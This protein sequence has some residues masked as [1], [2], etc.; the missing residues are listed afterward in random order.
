MSNASSRTTALAADRR[1]FSQRRLT[2]LLIA[3]AVV[4]GPSRGQVAPEPPVAQPA[5]PSAA[6]KSL[7][8]DAFG[9]APAAQVV[10]PAPLAL[11]AAP[12]APPDIA[13]AADTTAAT[14][15]TAATEPSG[16]P[17]GSVGPLTPADGGYGP[18]VFAGSDGRF[19]A[20]LLRRL[21]TPVASRWAH[22]VLRRA[23]LTEAPAPPGIVPGD[24]IAERARTL[25][26]MGEID[27]AKALMDNLPVDRFTPRLIRV[28]GQVHLAAADLPGLC[29]IADTG[30]AV[31]PD[32]LWKLA[33]AMCAAMAG[34]DITA[35]SGFDGLRDGDQVDPFDIM[36]GERV[37]TISG[38]GGGRAANVEW[39]AVDRVTPY[40]F[41]VATA[42]GVAV[43]LPQLAKLAATTGGTSWGWVLRAPGQAA[44]IRAAALRPAVAIGIASVDE[45]V[46]AIS[47]AS[48]DLDRAAL[49]ASPAGTL[50]AAYAAPTTAERVAAMRTIWAGGADEPDRYAAHIETALA[51]ARLPVDSAVA[52]DAPDLIAAMLSAGIEDRAAR[53][54]PVVK[55]GDDAASRTAWALLAVGAN[56]GIGVSPARY[57]A[58]AKDVSPHRAALLLAGL[59][60]L[61]HA[62]GS[63]WQSPREAAGL[64]VSNS[65]SQAIDAAA[66]AHRTGE[67]AVLAAT[68]LQAKWVAVSPAYLAHIV[69][70]YMAV[71]RSH[72]ARMLAAEAVTRG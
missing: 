39:D 20:G 60:G 5:S 2:L 18:A 22:I 16:P 68:G 1:H 21:R 47:A 51:A 11:P 58:Y 66:A 27:G 17:L 26:N 13:A 12:D 67:V 61:G 54:W 33:E 45:M 40:R 4:A 3:A 43:P 70:A 57:A 44:D 25:L 38:A 6:P 30:G 19:V 34:D 32:P 35:A 29:P 62:R 24:W 10:A 50:R 72:E 55:D 36:L 42:A 65:W 14:A 7:L 53:W 8:P 59:D 63:D 71:G 9:A 41:G 15:D 28:A 49:D 37:A 23:L 56:G 31:S 46:G 48:A 52:A 69:A 64:T